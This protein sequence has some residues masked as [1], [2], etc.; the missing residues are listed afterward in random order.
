MKMTLKYARSGGTLVEVEVEERKTLYLRISTRT[1]A[2][3]QVQI[4]NGEFHNIDRQREIVL[5]TVYQLDLPYALPSEIVGEPAKRAEDGPWFPACGGTETPF[6]SRSG[7]RLLY[8]WQPSTGN[9]AY[10]DC[11]SDIILTPEEAAQAMQLY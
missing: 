7:K 11:G 2:C 3:W 9:H 1:L 4:H 10:L 8:C 5:E 6:L